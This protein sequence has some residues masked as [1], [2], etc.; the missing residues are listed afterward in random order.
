MHYKKPA[1][2]ENLQFYIKHSTFKNLIL[3]MI[4]FGNDV[5]KFGICINQGK[6][7]VPGIAGYE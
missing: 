6:L 1:N 2:M 5:S 3:L 4:Y 7:S